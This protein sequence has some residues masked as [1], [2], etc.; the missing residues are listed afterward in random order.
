MDSKKNIH[1]KTRI[2][3]IHLKVSDQERCTIFYREI[4]EFEFVQRLGSKAAFLSAGGYPHPIGLN[5]W[6]SA[7]GNPPPA[8]STGFYHYVILVGDRKE[9]A[10]SLRRLQEM[11]TRYTATVQNRNGRCVLLAT[12]KC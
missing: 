2:G 7:N 3:H 6:E 4:L 1:P 5:P 12:L 9:F 11:E 8:G 10:K